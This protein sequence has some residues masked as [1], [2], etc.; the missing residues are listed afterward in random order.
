MATTVAIAHKLPVPDGTAV[1]NIGV[2][3][4][5]GNVDLDT[6]PWLS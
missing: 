6:L 4:S 1:L 3:I 2:V 5:G